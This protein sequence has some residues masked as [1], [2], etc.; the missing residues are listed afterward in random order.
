MVVSFYQN[1]G[2]LGRTKDFS[3]KFEEVFGKGAFDKFLKEWKSVTNGKQSEIWI[4]REDLSG[5]DGEMKSS[6]KQ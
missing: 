1:S 2:W 5:V 3:I 6:K 4:F